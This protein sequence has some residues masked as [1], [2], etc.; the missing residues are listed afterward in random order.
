MLLVIG[1]GNPL[2]SDDGLGQILAETLEDRWTV[3][4]SVQLTPELAEPISRAERVVFLDA[5]VGEMPG[6]VICEKVA[7]MPLVGAFTHNV[8]PASLLASAQELYG[9][10]PPAI[11]ISITGASFEYGFTFSPQIAALL[12]Q[13]IGQ[14]EEI[15]AAFFLTHQQQANLL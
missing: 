14:V 4:T 2:R 10:A 11:M 1:Y 6:K 5:G 15:I 13:I 8:T 12:P 7:P 3:I 9:A